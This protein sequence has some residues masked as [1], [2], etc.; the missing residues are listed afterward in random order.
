MHGAAAEVKPQSVRGFPSGAGLTRRLARAQWLPGRRD[1][2]GVSIAALGA[3]IAASFSLQLW[4]AHLHVPF[5]YGSDG[6]LTEMIIKSVVS[7]GWVWTNHALGAPFGFQLYDFPVATDSLNF[8]AMKILSLGTDDPAK[9]MNIF[10]LLTFP[11]DA[12]AGYAV[13]RWL[14]ISI[15]SSVVCAILFADAPYHLLRGETHLLLSSY[16]TVPIATYLTVA[17][18]DGAS[19]FSRRRQALGLRGWP[20]R[21]NLFM[22]VLCVMIGSLGIYYA[23]FTMLLVG[24]AGIAS[25]AGKRNWRPFVQA[26]AVIGA[27]GAMAFVNDLPGAIYRHQHGVDALVAHRLPQESE[28]YAL[29]LAE[30]VLPV[31]GHRVAPLRNIRQ[32]YD[33][34]T[35]TPT[36]AANEDGPQS[37]GIVGVI[38]LAWMF[39]IAL[40]AVIGIDR[41]VPWLRRQRQLA[42]A[43]LT[44][45]LIATVG[46]VSA[47]IGYLVTPQIRA[48]DRISIFIAFF[49]LATVG[50]GL[51]ALRRR[52]GPAHRWLV[53]VG[54]TVVLVIGIYDQSSRLAIPPYAGNETAYKDDGLFVA[55]IQRLMPKGASIFQLPY[56]AFPENPPVGRM[57]DYDP[58]RG[59]VHSTDLRWSYGSMKGR[60]QDW[61]NAAQSLPLPTLLDG[62]V[63]AGFSGLWIDRLG[64]ADSAASLQKRV[65]ALVGN[66]PIISRNGRFAFFDLR[67]F[68]ARLRARAPLGEIA[69]LRDAILHPP[70]V[71]R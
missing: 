5:A 65:R 21:R 47:L 67:A 20:S 62:V 11:A 38:G 60:P 24:S 25:S 30:M 58:G 44:A 8:L 31:P 9:V 18:L 23:A 10:F 34:T 42:F 57:K 16:I 14:G 35:T 33:T 29:K 7:G 6:L 28:L 68:A 46:G 37:L 64:Y 36:S 52:L 45:F 49:A 69:G 4:H 19:L 22:L 2:I 50:L 66:A 26:A 43:A 53:P 15:G 63:A 71:D 59:Y 27:I 3:C 13:L 12:I 51:D 1:V 61:E 41:A 48:W 32:K 39:V 55:S 17:I 56:V 54:L 70:T 40:G